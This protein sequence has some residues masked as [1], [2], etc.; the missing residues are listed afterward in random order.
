[1]LEWVGEKVLQKQA[2][3]F[4]SLELSLSGGND[5]NGFSNLLTVNKAKDVEVDKRD[6]VRVD[7]HTQECLIT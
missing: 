6:W 5:G 4:V 7:L 2:V 1:M 3:G